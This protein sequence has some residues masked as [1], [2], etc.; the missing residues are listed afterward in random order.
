MASSSSGY[1]NGE[2]PSTMPIFGLESDSEEETIA[3]SEAA[4]DEASV[5]GSIRDNTLLDDDFLADTVPT[6]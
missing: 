4:F 3:E 1:Q 5:L 2:G 6:R